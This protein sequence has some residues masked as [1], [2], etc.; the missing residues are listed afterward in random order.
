MKQVLIT[1]A[2]S[3]IGTSF[4]KYVAGHYSPAL[5]L[6]TIDMVDGN[7]RSYDFSPY[8]IVLHVAGLA[9]ADVSNVDEAI[10]K[11][12][13]A[14]NT[15]LAIETCKK[16]KDSGVKQFVF[17]SSAIIYGDSAPYGVPKRIT[18]NTEPKPV[19]FYGDSKWQADKGVRALAGDDFIVTVLRPPMIYGKGSKGNYPILAKMARKMPIFPDIQNE[20]SML[21][22]ENLCEFLCQ[23]MIRG[24]G[25]V[26]WPQNAEYIQTSSMVKAIAEACGHKILVSR[27]FDW[28]VGLSARIPGKI[29]RLTN[30]AFGNL[31]YDQALS[32]YDF[33]YQIYD[34]KTSIE[35]TEG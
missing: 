17:M 21:Y 28:V 14:I 35:R 33:N 6:I 31:S 26:Y 3:Y 11:K 29:S 7:W 5:H 19:N 9:H 2:N 10:K 24:C 4:E 13:Y 16:A 30:K 12:Y 15:D 1:G 32:Q 20:R 18:K 25:G 27:A 8:D 22:L 23:V 34:L